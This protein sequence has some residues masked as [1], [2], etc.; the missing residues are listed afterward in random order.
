M[1]HPN[2]APAVP[3]PTDASVVESSG[4]HKAYITRGATF[5]VAFDWCVTCLRHH[6]VSYVWVSVEQRSR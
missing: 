5:L 6:R 3:V 2:G 4:E 1:Y